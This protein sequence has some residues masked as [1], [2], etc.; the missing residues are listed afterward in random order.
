MTDEINWDDEYDTQVNAQSLEGYEF[1]EVS[2]QSYKLKTRGKHPKT[3]ETIMG[4]T[5]KTKAT[6]KNGE[7]ATNDLPDELKF[8][9]KTVDGKQELEKLAVKNTENHEIDYAIVNPAVRIEILK[10]RKNGSPIQLPIAGEEIRF[11]YVKNT[12]WIT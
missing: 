5:L 12:V 1:L 6:P 7:L 10:T 8:K 3:G 4:I 2:N 9:W 11:K